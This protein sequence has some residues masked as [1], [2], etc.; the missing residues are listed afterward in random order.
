MSHSSE[1]D[2]K[3]ELWQIPEVEEPVKRNTNALNM[4]PDW[5]HQ[6]VE[7]EIEELPPAP[8]SLE[9]IEAIR[10]D[11]YQEGFDQGRLAGFEQGE[12]Q[13]KAEGLV[14]GH[15]EGLAQGIAE[16]LAQGA[17]EIAKQSAIWAK[18]TQDLCQP[19]AHLDQEVE[20]QLVNLVL[21]LTQQIVKTEVTTNPKVIL[22]ALKQAIDVLPFATQTAKLHFHPDDIAMIETVYSAQECEKRGWHLI[23]EPSLQRGDCQV[24]TELSSVDYPLEMRINQVLKQFL[25]Q[26]NAHMQ[27]ALADAQQEVQEILPEPLPERDTSQVNEQENTDEV[28]SVAS[29]ESSPKHENVEEND[30]P[31]SLTEPPHDPAG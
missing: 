11:A 28:T 14:K 6:E 3:P 1:H 25:T 10:Q 8:P 27:Q 17:D 23:A 29:T 16:G 4:P 20:Q 7:E 19:V 9:E 5:Y 24:K 18:L 15:T 31:N 13:G 2:S 26:N 12:A 21:Q 22:G 30:D